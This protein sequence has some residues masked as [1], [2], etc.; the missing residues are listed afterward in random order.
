MTDVSPDRRVRDA[1]N[2]INA[3]KRQRVATQ[4]KAGKSVSQPG[5]EGGRVV[6]VCVVCV[7]RVYVLTMHIDPIA[8]RLTR[9]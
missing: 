7:G 6:G 1:M 4:E 2:E 5:S 8:Q 9:C 3:S